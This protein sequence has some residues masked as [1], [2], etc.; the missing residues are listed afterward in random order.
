MT[1]VTSGCPAIHAL[2]VG[3]G[4]PVEMTA[5]CRRERVGCPFENRNAGIGLIAPGDVQVTVAA[6][7]TLSRLLR[8]SRFA[9]ARNDIS[10]DQSNLPSVQD[11]SKRRHAGIRAA[12]AENNCL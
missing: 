4:G 6:M 3:K 9:C 12:A 2:A 1:W 7:V 10:S 8:A 11:F 5:F